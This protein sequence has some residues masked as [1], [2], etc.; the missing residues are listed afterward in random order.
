M[1]SI[2]SITSSVQTRLK[3]TPF[4][5]FLISPVFLNQREIPF[6]PNLTLFIGNC[7]IIQ[8]RLTVK[9]CCNST[10][11]HKFSLMI[12]GKSRNPRCFKDNT[13]PTMHYRSS[14]NAWQTRELFL[15]KMKLPLKAVLLLDNGSSHCIAEE[16]TSK[17]GNIRAF[18]FPPKKRTDHLH[19]SD[20]RAWLASY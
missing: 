10:G 15:T 6:A 1:D 14:K 11:Q 13:L 2:L 5:F 8:D 9:P 4:D 12:I 7:F 19:I 18:F 16:L 20:I 3:R 17:D